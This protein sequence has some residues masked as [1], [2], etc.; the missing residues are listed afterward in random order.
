[1]SSCIKTRIGDVRHSYAPYPHTVYYRVSFSE[2]LSYDVARQ[3]V[4]DELRW[5]YHWETGL[6][7]SKGLIIGPEPGSQGMVWIACQTYT[8]T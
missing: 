3:R 8:Y 1:M 7:Q 6:V 4:E 2:P 5:A